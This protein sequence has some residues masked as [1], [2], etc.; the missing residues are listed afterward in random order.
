MVSFSGLESSTYFVMVSDMSF[1]D[2]A[3]SLLSERETSGRVCVCIMSLQVPPWVPN[4]NTCFFDRTVC[5]YFG[6][7]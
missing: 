1:L 4:S 3:L 7:G 5:R 6:A 2:C